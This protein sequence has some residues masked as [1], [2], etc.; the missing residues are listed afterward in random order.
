VYFDSFKILKVLGRGAFGRVFLVKKKDSGRI[1]ALKTL[2]KIP[3][4]INE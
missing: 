4:I 2:E 3:L 1:Y